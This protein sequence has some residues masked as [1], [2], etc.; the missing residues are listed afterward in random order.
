M[1]PEDDIPFVSFDKTSIDTNNEDYKL[2][3]IHGLIYGD[4]TTTYSCVRVKGYMIRVCGDHED[5]LPFFDGYKRSYPETANGDPVVYL[6]DGFA[7]TH[8]LKKLPSEDEED[9]YLLGFM[10]GWMAADGY[11]SRSSQVSL[12][13]S[14]DDSEWI[15]RVMCKIGFVVQKVSRL[16]SKTNFGNRKIESC[17]VFLSRSSIVDQDLIIKRKAERFRSL[18][19]HFCVSSVEVGSKSATWSFSKYSLKSS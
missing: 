5:V 13:C 10:R 3:V 18:N 1:M 19:S 11:V 15:N 6:Y 2:G 16:P 17:H 12:C 4:G 8:S 14:K 7:K 9:S